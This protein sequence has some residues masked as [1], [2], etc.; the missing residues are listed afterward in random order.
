MLAGAGLRDVPAGTVVLPAASLAEVRDRLRAAWREPATRLGLWTHFATQ[1]SGTVFG[2][3]W[4]YPFLVVGQGLSPARAGLLLSLLVVA[5]VG[6]GP[7]LGALAGRWPFRRSVLVVGIVVA[8]A[9]AWTAVLAWPGRAPLWLL[10]VLVLVLA[11]NGPGS[12]LGFDY[13]R[14][15]NPAD[16][17]G[18]ASGIVNVGGFVASL[19][20][21]LAVGLVLD[22]LSGPGGY[23]LRE[24][25]AAFCLQYL[26]WALGLQRVAHH[27]RALRER[28]LAERGVLVDPLHRAVRR[29]VGA[30]RRASAPS[31]AEREQA[32]HD[33]D[34]LCGGEHGEPDP[35]PV[36][37][38][39]QPAAGRAEGEAAELEARGRRDDLR[40]QV[41]RAVRGPRGAACSPAPAPRSLRRPR[42]DRAP[43]AASAPGRRRRRR[44][45]ARRRRRRPP[46]PGRSEGRGPRPPGSR[47]GRPARRR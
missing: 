10:V 38:D 16:R 30:A 7:S 45:R 19:T 11:S 15:D 12:M 37:R 22:L 42:P 8:S 47:P 44:G 27:R 33:T 9:T 29:K 2:L 20:T 4:G 41:L 1:F 39:D 46:G 23:G 24:L 26:L 40:L 31:A 14:T 5:G 25:K 32:Q 3:L 43:P 36:R 21:V 35:H 18:S 6:I 17:L 34:H 13:A 28:R